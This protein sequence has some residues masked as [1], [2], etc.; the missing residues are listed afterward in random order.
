MLRIDIRPYAKGV[1]ELDFEPS[2]EELEVDADSFS[3]IKIEVRLDISAS[4]I[5]V[6]FRIAAIAKLVCDR[7]LVDFDQAIEG[8]YAVVFV[9]PK[10]ID[11]DDEAD[12]LFPLEAG[13]EEIDLTEIIRDTLLLAVP[14]RK[15]APGAEDEDLPITFGGPTDEDIDPRWTALNELRSKSD[16]D[17]R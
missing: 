7:T 2:A 13:A 3:K 12:N 4:R 16:G 11:P 5:Y 17:D 8:S 1:Y 10:D 14:I 6:Q 9:P 15:I